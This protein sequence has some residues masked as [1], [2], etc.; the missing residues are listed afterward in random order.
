MIRRLGRSLALPRYRTEATPLCFIDLFCGIGGF[1]I[2]F[3]RV[4]G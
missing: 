3:E 4:G 1:R 2:A